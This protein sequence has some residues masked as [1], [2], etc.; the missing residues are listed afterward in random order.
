MSYLSFKDCYANKLDLTVMEIT[1]G[2]YLVSRTYYGKRINAEM[3]KTP[4][5]SLI[6]EYKSTK[7]IPQEPAEK[8]GYA[9][10]YSSI[11]YDIAERY[12]ESLK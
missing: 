4:A 5:L 9:K 6:L 12:R 1:N 10:A 3:D 11:C 7:R 8:K 2:K